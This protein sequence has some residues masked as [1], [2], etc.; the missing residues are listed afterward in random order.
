M[1]KAQAQKKTVAAVKQYIIDCLDRVAEDDENRDGIEYRCEDIG[2]V[3]TSTCNAK[4]IY[5]DKK[6]QAAFK[7]FVSSQIG[8]FQFMEEELGYGSQDDE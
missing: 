1:N 8:S 7:K 3:D 2:T 6:V 5:E 4:A